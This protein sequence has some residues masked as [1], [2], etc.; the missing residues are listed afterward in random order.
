MTDSS[1]Q[2][3]QYGQ[4]SS[5]MIAGRYEMQVEIGSGA[6]ATTWRGLD[7]RLGRLV[8]IKVLHP[9]FASDPAYVQRFEREAQAAASVS[10]G[11]VVDVYDF[12]RQD[13]LLYIVM[14][15]VAGED[16][17]HLI[18][19]ERVLAPERAREIVLQILA[20]LGAIHAAGIVHR[21]V[22]PQNMLVGTDGLVRVADFGIA[23]QDDQHQLTTTGTAFG[24]AAYMAPEQ[25]EGTDVGP[26]TDMYAVGVVLYELLTGTLPFAGATP[27]AMMLAHLQQTPEWPSQRAT[28]WPISADLDGVVMQALQKRPQDRFRTAA[29]MS[30]AL[31]HASLLGS[32]NP[33]AGATEWATRPQPRPQGQGRP[34]SLAS[35][36]PTSSPVGHANPSHTPSHE[37]S[38]LSAVMR[39]F[40]VLALIA[41]IGG[42]FYLWQ[43]GFGRG[44]DPPGTATV[45]VTQPIPTQTSTEE[46]GLIL[47]STEEPTEE[48]TATT[49]PT[50]TTEPTATA[51]ATATSEPSPTESA[52]TIEPIGPEATSSGSGALIEPMATQTSAP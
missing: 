16:L 37:G 13:D 48:P 31:R 38:G 45:S 46:S 19:R 4:T 36:P 34:A 27:M 41:A 14:Q 23:H 44:A 30:Q 26:A 42:A 17:K 3:G 1:D 15:Y 43:S 8:A 6:F 21:D 32:S 22:K 50:G 52:P 39:A 24:T 25:A 40:L 7:H 9:Q 29:A 47:P 33:N 12:G 20:G 2:T 5:R 10:H 11:N 28:R 49:E 51:T 35:Q 18:M